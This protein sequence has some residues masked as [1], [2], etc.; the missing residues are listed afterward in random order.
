MN[1]LERLANPTEQEKL[2]TIQDCLDLGIK[3]NQREQRKIDELEAIYNKEQRD[4][5]KW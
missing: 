2:E 3:L 4:M 5:M 1:I